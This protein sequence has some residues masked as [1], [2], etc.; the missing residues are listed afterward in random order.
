MV[1]QAA[2]NRSI[3]VRLPV[4]QP[5]LFVLQLRAP[6]KPQLEQAIRFSAQISGALER[7]YRTGVIHRDAATRSHPTVSVHPALWRLQPA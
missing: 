3:G 5:L 6:R 4:S 7:A 1:G 2:L